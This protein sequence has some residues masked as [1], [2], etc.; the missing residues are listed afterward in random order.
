V[1]LKRYLVVT[2]ILALASVAFEAWWLFDHGVK[3]TP[4]E[5]RGL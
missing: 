2:S 1:K 3:I 5:E 4:R